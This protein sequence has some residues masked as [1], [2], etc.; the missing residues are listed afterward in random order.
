MTPVLV[1]ASYLIAVYNRSDS[2]HN[3]CMQVNDTLTR[4]LVTC[5]PVIAEAMHML[6]KIPKAGASILASIEHQLVLMPFSV[7]QSVSSVARLMKKY[8]D[9]PAD[10]ADACLI[11]MAD[12]LNTGDILTLDSD[13]RHYRWRRN[14]RFNL[15]ISTE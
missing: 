15:L 8:S 10:L 14:K 11:Q 9:T 12:D 13:F 3:Q 6:R 5:E 4:P 2:F 1:D 7:S